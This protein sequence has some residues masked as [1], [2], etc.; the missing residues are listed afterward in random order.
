MLH[1]IENTNWPIK[2]HILSYNKNSIYHVLQILLEPR[3]YSTYVQLYV[4][5]VYYVRQI[6]NLRVV[7]VKK[8]KLRIM[9]HYL[10]N[11]NAVFA[12]DI[13]L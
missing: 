6:I 9:S 5:L 4:M 7:I 12:G 2:M 1:F 13:W 8:R 11:R 3:K 10:P